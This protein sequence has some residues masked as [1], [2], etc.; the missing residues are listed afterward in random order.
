V[1][2]RYSPVRHSRIATSVRLA[3]VRPAASVRSEPGSNSQV[4]MPDHPEKARH[5]QKHPHK[6]I[7]RRP[8]PKDTGTYI[9]CA[10]KDEHRTSNPRPKPKAKRPTT[11]AADASLPLIQLV[12][13]RSAEVRKKPWPPTFIVGQN[14]F[15]APFGGAPYTLRLEAL[16]NVV[17][18]KNNVRVSKRLRPCGATHIGLAGQPISVRI[19]LLSRVGQSPEVFLRNT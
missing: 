10:C 16:S 18:R 19:P 4:Q 11:I 6:H 15:A 1:P 5:R 12:K 3:C 7:K 17:L 8:M 13:E 14:P 2:T 9:R